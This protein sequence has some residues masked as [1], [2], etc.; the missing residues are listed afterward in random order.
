[1]GTVV[2]WPHQRRGTHAAVAPCELLGFHP[3]ANVLCVVALAEGGAL[4]PSCT[5]SS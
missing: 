4:F 3:R 1:M 2:Y 5:S